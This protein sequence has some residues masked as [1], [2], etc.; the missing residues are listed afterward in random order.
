MK[1]SNKN[2][3]IRTAPR[4]AWESG[5]INNQKKLPKSSISMISPLIVKETDIL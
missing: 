1:A 2:K 3:S 4:G 5:D